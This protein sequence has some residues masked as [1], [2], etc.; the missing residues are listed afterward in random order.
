MSDVISLTLN[1]LKHSTRFGLIAPKLP[2]QKVT[3]ALIKDH[4]TT[5]FS[6]WSLNPDKSDS[7]M[8]YALLYTLGHAAPILQGKFGVHLSFPERLCK[9]WRNVLSQLCK[10]WKFCLKKSFQRKIIAET[11]SSTLDFS[12]YLSPFLKTLPQDVRQVDTLRK[13]SGPSLAFISWLPRKCYIYKK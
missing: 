1:P 12:H 5:R 3:R 2:S 10:I 11:I 13:S 4:I 9:S 6:H 7:K 8:G